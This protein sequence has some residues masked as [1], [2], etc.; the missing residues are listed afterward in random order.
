MWLDFYRSISVQTGRPLNTDLK[1]SFI[2]SA[3]LSWIGKCF[4][5]L[6]LDRNDFIA[7]L[8]G[9][10]DDGRCH[11]E[12]SVW[13]RPD[14]FKRYSAGDSKNRLI[15]TN[16]CWGQSRAE[17]RKSFPSRRKNKLSSSDKIDATAVSTPLEKQPSMFPVFTPKHRLQFL[18]GRWFVQLWFSHEHIAW[19]R[20]AC[21]LNKAWMFAGHNSLCLFERWRE[22]LSPNEVR[23]VP[24][25][26]SQH[27]K[28]K[29]LRRC[30]VW[31]DSWH[32]LWIPE[33]CE[34]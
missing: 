21:R 23:T 11:T 20:Y 5:G 28:I 7:W 29:S 26:L 16:L 31:V 13:T 22:Y 17:R 10:W 6:I 24:R 4:I 34:I 33:I 2:S 14:T 3:R 15:T 9:R 27:K 25:R 19:I 32:L 18:N 12:R 1:M 8:F 30:V